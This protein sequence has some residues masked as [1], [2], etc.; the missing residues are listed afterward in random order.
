MD[1]S[2][3]PLNPIS[4]FYQE[5]ETIQSPGSQI[6]ARE[7]LGKTEQKILDIVLLGFFLAF[8]IMLFIA[9]L[10]NWIEHKD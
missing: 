7:S 10:V 4:P 6:S 9:G 5:M 2:S 1:Q 8:P 3:H